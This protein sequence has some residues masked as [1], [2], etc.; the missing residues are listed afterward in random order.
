MTLDPRTMF[1]MG[2]GFLIVTAVTL[3]LL[4][5]TLPQDIRRSATTGATATALLALS[6]LLY[7]FDGIAPE[8]LTLVVGN[9]LYLVAIA[10]V[11]QSIRLLDGAPSRPTF[12]LVTVLPAVAIVVAARYVVNIYEVR[13][14]AMSLAIT[15][16]LGLSARRLFSTATKSPQG[17]RPAAYWML[18]G[19]A[20][21]TARAVLAAVAD[22]A[23]PVLSSELTPSLTVALSVVVALGSAFAYFHIFNGR[24]T[25]ELALQ[26]HLD[27]LTELLNRRGFEDRAQQELQRSARSGAP[28]SLLMIDANEFKA[29]NDKWGHQAG[30]TAL[31]AIADGIRTCIRPYDVV[32]RL[33]GDEFVVL[34]PGLDANDVR[35]L[36]PRVKESIANQPTG[37]PTKLDVGIGRATL[38]AS[39][40][41]GAARG[42]ANIDAERHVRDLLA[43]ADKDMYSVKNSRF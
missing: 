5:R 41:A 18:V 40:I 28:V 33:G 9:G 37:L 32:A 13:V 15:V 25:S 38:T 4:V 8:A 27:S 2:S 34:L 31:C 35:I 23:P 43:E 30:D 11:Y 29:I 12:W 20:L 14:A 19:A 39:Q 3:A 16:L 22:W 42:A 21:L 1:V 10:L 6:W 7:A 24:L 26:A 17:R 36:V